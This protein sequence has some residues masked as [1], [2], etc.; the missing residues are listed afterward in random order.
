MRS[1]F[2]LKVLLLKLALA[3]VVLCP[4]AVEAMAGPGV[5]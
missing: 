1:L 2:L 3:I 5:P 4:L